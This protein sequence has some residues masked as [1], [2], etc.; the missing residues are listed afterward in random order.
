MP[1]FYASKQRYLDI[2]KL[3]RICLLTFVVDEFSLL[4][5]RPSMHK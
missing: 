1:I 3:D 5:L 4:L 2:E